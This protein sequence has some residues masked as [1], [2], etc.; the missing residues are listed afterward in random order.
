MVV[1]NGQET[2]ILESR[3]LSLHQISVFWV[4]K[5]M[6]MVAQLYDDF[7]TEFI[8][9]NNHRLQR[10]PGKFQFVKK[11]LVFFILSETAQIGYM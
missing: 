4:K 6:S 7:L 3:V 10:F 5:L 9:P 1:A 2:T 11:R 8:Y